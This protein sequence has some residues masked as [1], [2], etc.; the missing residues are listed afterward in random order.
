MES[1]LDPKLARSVE[2]LL[3]GFLPIISVPLL[4]ARWYPVH[5]FALD[6]DHWYWPAAQRL[7]HGSSPYAPSPYRAL[8]Y[9]APAALLF[10]P[11]ALIPHAVADWIF[12]ALV[13]AAV[14][15]SL[16]LL[17]V[18]DWR[19]YGIVFLWQPVIVGW[20]TANISL[21]LLLGLA[22][23]W[24]LRERPLVVGSLLAL[25]I[26][27]KIFPIPI[28][29]WLLATRRFKA[30]AWAVGTSIVLNLISWAVA[31]FGQIHR[32]LQILSAVQG[33][34]E[35]RG[36]SLIS[37]ALQFGA[38]QTFAYA[39]G[40]TAA[41]GAIGASLAIHDGRRDRIV[42]IACIA[43]CLLTSPLVE[44]H[45]LA[46]LITPLALAQPT[47]KPI[48][49]LPIIL[50]VTPADYPDAWQ[51]V[52]A[53]CVFAA[54]MAASLSERR[55]AKPSTRARRAATASSCGNSGLT[56]R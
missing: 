55:L 7:L 39:I 43:A 1:A 29:I 22:A 12:T 4:L 44:S 5:N 45:Y 42:F 2:R 37:L 21:L 26:C 3:V 11:F 36:Y 32:Y 8:N 24:C 23:C 41:A 6:F 10:V 35:R 46:L 14:P 30:L 27:V 54:I 47:L 25:L 33:P 34:D 15:A 52:L 48:W 19:I 18:R 40:I 9:P 20:Q 31:G 56:R 16:W 17:G 49:G 53:L 13:L 28:L 51:H 50:I 38:S